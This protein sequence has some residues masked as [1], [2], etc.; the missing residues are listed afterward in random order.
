MPGVNNPNEMKL[1]KL[2]Y[3]LQTTRMASLDPFLG[4]NLSEDFQLTDQELNKTTERGPLPLYIYSVDIFTK[5][6]APP[7]ESCSSLVLKLTQ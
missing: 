5:R 2:F 1:C 3:S 7:Q 6:A 4:E